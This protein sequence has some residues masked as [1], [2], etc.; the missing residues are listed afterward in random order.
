MQTIQLGDETTPSHGMRGRSG[1][2]FA[3]LH[4]P[5][6]LQAVG[7]ATVQNLRVSDMENVVYEIAVAPLERYLRQL[8]IPDAS[9]LYRRVELDFLRENITEEQ[10]FVVGDLWPGGLLL[11]SSA[12]PDKVIGVIDIEFSG[13]GRACTEIWRSCLLICGSIFMV[14]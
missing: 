1:R 13:L 8:D 12:G 14:P 10:A 7:S 4:S 11:G 6:S 3:G 2:F 9:Q 5:H